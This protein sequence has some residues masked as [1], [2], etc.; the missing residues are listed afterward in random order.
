MSAVITAAGLSK[1]YQTG[2]GPLR[3]LDWLARGRRAHSSGTVHALDALDFEICRGE[4]VGL[5]GRNGAGKSTL[6]RVVSGIHRPSDGKL[7]VSG[8]VRAVLDLQSLFIPLLSGREN[9]RFGMRLYGM[10]PAQERDVE[11]EAI[12]FSELGEAI[13]APLQTYSSGM[14]LRL[15]FSLATARPPEILLIDEILLVGD[16]SFRQKC[17]A[18][19]KDL[20]AHGTTV[21][22]ASH[23]LYLV[24]KLCA[25]SLWLEQGRL[26]SDGPSGA[27]IE[28]YQR[29]L[30]IDPNIQLSAENAEV[31]Q[32]WVYRKAD[33]TPF[34]VRELRC[35]DPGGAEKSRFQS[36]EPFGVDMLIEPDGKRT[37]MHLM[38]FI[39]RPDGTLVAQD[40]L[41]RSLDGSGEPV[42]VRFSL[43]NLPLGPGDYYVHLA[44]S[45]EDPVAPHFDYRTQRRAFTVD[46]SAL[47][48]RFRRGLVCLSGN[49]EVSE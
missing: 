40:V 22:F 30:D 49:W 20:L 12:A 35:I 11:A 17:Y 13:D 34:R 3:I 37:A 15:G 43:G 7:S 45:E 29:F 6:L 18:R 9:L 8:S 36:G 46:N 5:I 42:R 33:V 38:F 16:E 47:D 41:E 25:R 2:R 14:M 39:H 10:D 44:L 32:E 28:E 24:E 26:A 1:T 21:L 48:H 23:D 4:A 27:V 31:L 19:A